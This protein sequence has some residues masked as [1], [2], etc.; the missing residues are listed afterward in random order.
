MVARP[1]RPAMYTEQTSNHISFAAALIAAGIGIELIIRIRSMEVGGMVDIAPVAAFFTWLDS[2]KI[3]AIAT[4]ASALFAGTIFLV[5]W[6][7]LRHTRNV[8]RA[9]LSGGG[10]LDAN[11]LDKFLFTVNNYGKTPGILTEYAVEFCPLAAIPSTPAYEARGYKRKAFHDRIAPGGI[12]ETRI[13]ASID[14]PPLPRPLLVYG[15]YWFEDIWKKRHTSGFV[16]VI[17]PNGTDGHLPTDIPR[18]YTD[19]N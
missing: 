10:P 7:Q 12:K 18:A 19:W 13:V 8:E 14:I 3:T 11:N 6:R 15:R 5:N 16:L 9:Y 17:H 4:V 1:D 2:N